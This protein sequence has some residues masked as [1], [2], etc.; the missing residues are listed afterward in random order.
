[1]PTKRPS[2]GSFTL[3]R[4]KVY[5]DLHAAH[6]GQGLGSSDRS[7]SRVTVMAMPVASGSTVTAPVS[8]SPAVRRASPA[9]SS[10]SLASVEEPAACIT[11][12]RPCLSQFCVS[13]SDNAPLSEFN[14]YEEMTALFFSDT[15]S[16]WVQGR[17]SEETSM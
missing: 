12:E 9:S 11:V 17:L 13:L 1:M 10:V 16:S 4:R 6:L 5:A 2:R 14:V 3:A 7:A 8:G 15:L